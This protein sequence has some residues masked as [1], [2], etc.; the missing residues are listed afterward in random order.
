V[1]VT[2]ILAL[3]GQYLWV[4]R[5]LPLDSFLYFLPLLDSGPFLLDYSHCGPRLA[6]LSI[7]ALARSIGG[8]QPSCCPLIKMNYCTAQP[9]L[10]IATFLGM[11]SQLLLL[12]LH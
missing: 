3:A 1:P 9:V 6:Y 2:A 11:A 10:E 7:H 5:H 4:A 8:G 12:I